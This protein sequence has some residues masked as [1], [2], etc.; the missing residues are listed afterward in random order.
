MPLNLVFGYE[1]NISAVFNIF[2][3]FM[4]LI[5]SVSLSVFPP[6]QMKTERHLP[7]ALEANMGKKNRI[8]LQKSFPHKH[9]LPT[10]WF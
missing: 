1:W 8:I 4:F 5:P 3:A 10:C 2:Y 7:E 6:T 9:C